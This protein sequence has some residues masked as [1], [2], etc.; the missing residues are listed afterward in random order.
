MVNPLIESSSTAWE[1]L[2]IGSDLSSSRIATWSKWSPWKCESKTRSNRGNWLTSIA[3]FVSLVV[4]NPYPRGTFSCI[5]INVGSVSIVNPAYLIRTVAFPIKKID[6]FVDVD[7]K[8]L[9]DSKYCYMN[10]INDMV[11][12][13]CRIIISNNWNSSYKGDLFILLV[14]YKKFKDY[15]LPFPIL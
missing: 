11:I 13:S 9:F 4:S 12:I 2:T 5:W 14:L 7:D 8:L 10:R 15:V 6:P 1:L 3:G